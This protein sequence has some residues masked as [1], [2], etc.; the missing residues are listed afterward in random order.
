MDGGSVF[1]QAA[2]AISCRLETLARE[3][4]RSSCIAL[5]PSLLEPG[6]G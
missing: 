3:P 1:R 6:G 5:G 2:S 4:S